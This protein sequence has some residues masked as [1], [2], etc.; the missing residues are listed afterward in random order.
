VTTNPSAVRQ[1]LLI[2]ETAP[3]QLFRVARVSEADR[4]VSSSMPTGSWVARGDAGVPT[5]SL[6]VLVDN[7][8]GYAVLVDRPVDQWSVSS[9][10]SIDMCAPIEPGATLYGQARP[11]ISD[12]RGA[13]ASGEV[14]DEDG[15]LVAVCRQHGRYV[16]HLPELGAAD[17]GVLLRPDEPVQAGSVLD[18]LGLRPEASDER[19]VLDLLATRSLVNPLRNVH[20]GIT[21]CA[22]DLTALA[23]LESS[24]RPMETASIHV[25]YVRPIPLGTTARFEATVVHSGRSFAVAR[26]DARNAEGKICATATVTAAAR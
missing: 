8:L 18:L 9:E 26:V 12:P 14:V 24:G 23:A 17:D 19:A 21:L 7:V 11:V 3:E 25:A 16:R 10:I 1:P 22:A 5:G 15:R 13:V 2:V 4:V 6:G 20:G